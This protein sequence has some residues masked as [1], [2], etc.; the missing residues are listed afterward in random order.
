M[1]TTH[2]VEHDH[3]ERRGSRTLV[4]VTAHVKAGFIRAPVNHRVDEPAI[5]VGGEDDR[6]ILGEQRDERHVI[7]SMRMI[8]RADQS[9]QIH[10][11]DDPHLDAG[12]TLLQE[13]RGRAYFDRWHIAGTSAHHVRLLTAVVGCKLPHRRTSRA[14]FERFVHVQPL[15]LRLFTAGYDVDVVSAPQTMVK[16]I[17]QT[18]AIRWIVH[19]DGFTPA[20]QRVVD[21]SGRL[22]AE[23]VVIVSSGM[24]CEKNIQ[25]C[26]RF[27]PGK[28]AALLQPFAC[29]V[30]IESTTCAK[31]S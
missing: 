29:C 10:H 26:E 16:D 5:V 25:Q 7:H 3:V 27:A 24:T 19:T 28:I 23:P 30:N 18:I 11:I 4:H 20:R 13:P 17:Q 9:H 14:M 31:A 21:K 1:K 15:K 12:N 6:R 22:M 2:L 8:V